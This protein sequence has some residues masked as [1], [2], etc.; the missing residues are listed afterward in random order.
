MTATRVTQHVHAPRRLVYQA[1]LDAGA[2]QRWMVPDGMTSRVHTFEPSDPSLRGEM[3]ITIRLTDASA[4]TQVDAVHDGL[5][6]GLSPSENEVGW[7]MSLAKLAALCESLT[8]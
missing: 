8:S 4:G 1:F 2:V 5:P 6:P 3:T 7:R